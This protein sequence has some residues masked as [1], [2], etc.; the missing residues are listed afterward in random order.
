[1]MELSEFVLCQTKV[2]TARVQVGSD[3]AR[4][5][6]LNARLS[7]ALNHSGGN[8]ALLC[9]DAGLWFKGAARLA[10]RRDQALL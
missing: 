10:L 6:A 7:G 2:I 9:G 3:H 1:M 8:Q 4:P 5:A